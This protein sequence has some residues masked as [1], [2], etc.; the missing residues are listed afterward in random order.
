MVILN[1]L[2]LYLNFFAFMPTCKI[3]ISIIFIKKNLTDEKLY[4]WLSNNNNI[5]SKLA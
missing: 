4:N 5:F 2:N 3:L 1:F